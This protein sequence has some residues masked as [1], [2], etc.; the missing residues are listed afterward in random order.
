MS[1]HT[2]QFNHIIY[3]METNWSIDLKKF[4]SSQ[5]QKVKIMGTQIEKTEKL[6]R[7]ISDNL[8]RF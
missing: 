7:Q 5:I 1:A 4:E 3:L 8:K 2:C 6:T